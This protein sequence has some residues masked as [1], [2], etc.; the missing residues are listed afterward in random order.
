MERGPASEA[1]TFELALAAFAAP[2]GERTHVP[3]FRSTTST[4]PRSPETATTAM[5]AVV[6]VVW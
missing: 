5:V 6:V 1:R 2:P 4:P 3:S